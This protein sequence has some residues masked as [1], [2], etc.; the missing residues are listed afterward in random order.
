VRVSVRGERARVERARVRIPLGESFF[1]NFFFCFEGVREAVGS[2]FR[3]VRACLT[4]VRTKSRTKY[5]KFYFL[6]K[7]F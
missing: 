2:L 6:P 7:L 1:E 5:K 3:V 4:K